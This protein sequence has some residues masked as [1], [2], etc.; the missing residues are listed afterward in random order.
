[1][2][3]YA[4]SINNAG[5]GFL[6]IDINDGC[7]TLTVTDEGNYVLSDE[8]GHLQADFTDFRQFIITKPDG[9]TFTFDAE[10]NGDA[11]VSTASSG[12]HTIN[13]SLIESDKDGVWDVQI[14]SV[15]TYNNAATYE[16]T[17]MVWFATKLY[18]SLTNANTGNQPDTSPTE[19]SVI[20][21][22]DLSVKYC[23]QKKVALTCVELLDCYERKNHDAACVIDQDFCNPDLLCK[24]PEL[25]DAIQLRMLLDAIGFSG[26]NQQWQNV[27]RDTNNAKK[28]CN[29]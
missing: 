24:N 27:E 15:P 6:S 7:D 14:Y 9:T 25:I 13:Y 16:N 23:V 1:M 22:A 8:S 10:G 17:D 3:D 11:L 20:T 28:I 19:W 5:T 29:C 12:N 4:I 26:R 21:I 18:K 2:P